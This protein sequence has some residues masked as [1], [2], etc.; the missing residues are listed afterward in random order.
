MHRAAVQQQQHQNS[1]VNVL[2]HQPLFNLQHTYT[3]LAH[4]VDGV[5]SSHLTL[6]ALPL[7][8]FKIFSLTV[9]GI[10]HITSSPPHRIEALH[11]TLENIQASSTS[12]LRRGKRFMLWAEGQCIAASLHAEELC[13]CFRDRRSFLWF[14][15]FNLWRKR[16]PLI[17]PFDS[18]I[19]HTFCIQIFRVLLWLVFQPRFI[20]YGLRVRYHTKCNVTLSAVVFPSRCYETWKRL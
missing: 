16:W 12:G 8:S 1:S 14:L 20:I 7:W 13:C 9:Q 6:S 15:S 18:L 11:L 19:G 3:H 17:N 10:G 4:L 5:K 2:H